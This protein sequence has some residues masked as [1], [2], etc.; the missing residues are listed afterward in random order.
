MAAVITSIRRERIGVRRNENRITPNLSQWRPV[1][2]VG[3]GVIAALAGT[4]ILLVP[5]AGLFVK[6]GH[7]VNVDGEHVRTHWSLQQAVSTLAAAPSDFAS[8]YRWTIVLSVLTGLTAMVIGW[9]LAAWARSDPRV[10]RGADIVSIVAF[11]IPG[12]V[13][14]LAVVKLFQFGFP[15]SDTLYQRTLVPT[16]IALSF[17]AVPIAYWVMRAGYRIFDQSLMDASRMDGN[18]WQRMWSID[19]RMLGS[20]LFIAF[21]DLV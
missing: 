19:R 9:P 16:V 17:R 14:G 4:G 18:A 2:Q 20:S 12:P 15:G 7:Q 8:E 1:T 13:V 21:P 11:M 10:R 5:V 6:V 3:A